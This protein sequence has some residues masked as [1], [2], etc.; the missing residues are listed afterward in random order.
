[1]RRM[2]ASAG[3][4]HEAGSL[5]S[6]GPAASP[7]ARS[8]EVFGDHWSILFK[9]SLGAYTSKVN[10]TQRVRSL[11]LLRKSIRE[12][13][14]RSHW[15]QIFFGFFMI[16]VTYHRK[17]SMSLYMFVFILCLP[18][19]HVFPSR[20]PHLTIQLRKQDLPLRPFRL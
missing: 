11:K 14:S 19:L 17:C 18:D 2:A 5:I 1:M 12:V 8:L 7:R 20:P 15:E 4:G 6:G 9:I 13:H 3:F 16:E 10:H